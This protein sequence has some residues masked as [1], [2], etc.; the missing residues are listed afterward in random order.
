MSSL[1][2][3]RCPPRQSQDVT[4]VVTLAA[5]D[6]LLKELPGP[7]LP[8]NEQEL[9][10][11]GAFLKAG[12]HDD[13]VA[14]HGLVRWCARAAAGVPPTP[15]ALVQRC[16]RCGGPHGRPRLPTRPDVHLSLSHSA[17][18]VAA[19]AASSPVGVDVERFRPDLV[20]R[21]NT[22][23]ALSPPEARMLAAT[24]DPTWTFLL[25]WVRKEA[26]VKLGAVTLDGMRGVDL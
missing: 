26:M 6:R 9:R 16:G 13:Y 17:G 15:D 21:W 8:L 3:L 20:N 4:G 24:R 12:D 7:Q 18:V 5:T 19:A 22:S 14:A 11:A 10:R 25:L 2:P 1:S 23:L